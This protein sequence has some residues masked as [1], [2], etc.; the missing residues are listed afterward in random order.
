M[1]AQLR[2]THLKTISAAIN[3]AL[4]TTATVIH[5]AKLTVSRR[6]NSD[7]YH[8]GGI[9]VKDEPPPP[10]LPVAKCWRA[11]LLA[12]SSSF[13]DQSRRGLSF[14]AVHPFITTIY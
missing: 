7:S 9:G 11:L 4:H 2:D 5:F 1:M 3:T 13:R 6:D 10:P 12:S 8:S 14:I